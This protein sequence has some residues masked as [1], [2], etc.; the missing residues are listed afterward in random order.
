MSIILDALKK[1][2]EE[3]KRITEVIVST[4]ARGY[5]KKQGVL[6]IIAAGL[7]VVL[8]IVLF[9][10]GK[11]K[12]D[13][14]G[15]VGV[16]NQP[17][18][19][20]PVKGIVPSADPPKTDPKPAIPLKEN[21]GKSISGR[22]SQKRDTESNP[23]QRLVMPGEDKTLTAKKREV[24]RIARKE[25][26][27]PGTPSE[28][29]GEKVLIKKNDDEDLTRMFNRA[30]TETEKGK[31][32]EAKKLYSLI[33]M[34]KPDHIETLN[35]LGVIAM[36]EDNAEKAL[37]YF[38]KALEYNSNYAKAYNNV[39]L[40][41]MKQ[42][43]RK[44]AAEYLRK[45]IEIDRENVGSYLNLAAILRQEKRLDEASALL[46]TALSKGLRDPAL[47]LSFALIKDDMGRREE[48]IRYYR[49]YLS[50]KSNGEERNLIVNRLRLLEGEPSSA[51][52]NK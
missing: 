50:V 22:E 17:P 6:Y 15:S 51:G 33:L 45:A 2:Q 24:P 37:S 12:A 11:K 47:Y 29:R 30:V 36:K 46:E 38:S 5:N 1:A 49:Y 7:L 14:V 8:A 9:M 21:K 4:S 34:E 39:A 16:Q 25:Q 20:S 3:R 19:T 18:I 40:I 32:E 48:A 31:T 13:N 10:P 44:L 52:Q 43:S 26:S 41:R 42:G 27:I 28:E 23:Q 35:N